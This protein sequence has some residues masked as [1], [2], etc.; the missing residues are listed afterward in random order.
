MTKVR[1]QNVA[2]DLFSF[3]NDLQY[4]LHFLEKSGIIID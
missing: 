4:T 3:D 2:P 1:N